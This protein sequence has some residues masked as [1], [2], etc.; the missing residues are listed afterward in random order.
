MESSNNPN[1]GFSLGNFFGG[2]MERKK[3]DEAKGLD[4]AAPDA[5]GTSPNMVESCCT[6]FVSA[7]IAFAKAFACFER[8]RA[9]GPAL[10]ECIVLGLIVVMFS[11]SSSVSRTKE[12]TDA[13]SSCPIPS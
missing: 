3:G 1:R 12:G 2:D 7:G 4:D 5:R 9:A 6:S 11:S 8:V 10:L 13:I